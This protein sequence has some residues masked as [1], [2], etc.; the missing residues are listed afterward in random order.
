MLGGNLVLVVMAAV[1]CDLGFVLTRAPWSW[2]VVPPVVSVAILIIALRVF[3]RVPARSAE[4][5]R[6]IGKL[7]GLWSAAE[8]IAFAIVGTILAN[9]GLMA[10]IPAALAVIVGLH[11]LPLA[12]GTPNRLYYATGTAMMAAGLANMVAPAEF[13]VR[14]LA[15]ACAL[16]LWGTAVG[17]LAEPRFTPTRQK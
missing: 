5:R 12:R 16:I 4:E 13:G 7:V 6:R 1:W 8:G 10:R 9:T 17:S 15:I 14:A 11:F 3:A 2:F